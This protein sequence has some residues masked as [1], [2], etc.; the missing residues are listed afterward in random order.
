M[1][2]LVATSKLTPSD[3]AQRDL[4]QK[5]ESFFQAIA[6]SSQA[7]HSGY[8]AYFSKLLERANYTPTSVISAWRSRFDAQMGERVSD[9]WIQ[10]LHEHGVFS[11]AAE[12]YSLARSTATTAIQPVDTLLQPQRIPQQ[13]GGDD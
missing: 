4:A 12:P 9:Q 2:A 5:M 1:S 13:S 11:Y 8:C 3:L 6:N 10:W 7:K